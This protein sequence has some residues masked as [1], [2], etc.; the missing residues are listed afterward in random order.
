M[1]ISTVI[2]IGLFVLALAWGLGNR[3]NKIEALVIKECS[4]Q[5]DNL[6]IESIKQD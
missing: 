4:T 6:S 5:A 1:N 3:L 2:P